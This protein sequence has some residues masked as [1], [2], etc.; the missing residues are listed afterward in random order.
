M[1]NLQFFFYCWDI[2]LLNY[3]WPLWSCFDIDVLCLLSMCAVPSFITSKILTAVFFLLAFQT[4]CPQLKKGKIMQITKQHIKLLFH[5]M[6]NE[7]S[8]SV[9]SQD[10]FSGHFHLRSTLQHQQHSVFRRF[11]RRSLCHAI[12]KMKALDYVMKWG[13]YIQV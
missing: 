5:W 3:K 7:L 9:Y 1:V 12:S 8:F 10:Q 2:S 6:T 4:Y 11:C 13:G